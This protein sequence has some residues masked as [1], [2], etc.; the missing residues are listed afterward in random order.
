[1]SPAEVAWRARDQVLRAGLVAAAGKPGQLA[2]AALPL[3]GERASSPP[4]CRRAPR[5]RVPAEARAA[6]LDS[7]DRLLRGEWE[8]LGVA[9]TDLV[10]P[11]WFHDPVTGRRSAPDR[12]AFRIDH[13]SEEQVGNVKQVWETLPAAAP[14]AA[15]HRLVAHRTRRSTR[16]RV[17][18]QLRSLVAGESVPVRRAL[19]QRHRAR[20]PPDQPGLDPAPAGRLARAAGLCSSSDALALQQIHWHQQYLAAF[21]SRGSSANNHVI[22][23]AGGSA[24]G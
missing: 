22:A 14:D 23:E 4:S 8:V 5:E 18:E 10:Q 21:P 16:S 7:A 2:E 6:V 19:D 20:H 17:A 24:R 12:Y 9:R 15:G 13:R 3:P 1:M 11:D